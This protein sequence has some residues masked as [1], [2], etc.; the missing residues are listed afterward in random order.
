MSF[1]TAFISTLN[2]LP[3]LFAI[4]THSSNSDINCQVITDLCTL[5]PVFVAFVGLSSWVS[6]VALGVKQATVT[7]LPPLRGKGTSRMTTRKTKG[8]A[9]SQEVLVKQV[10]YYNR[11]ILAHV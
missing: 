3:I 2:L 7:A 4:N 8:L 6:G 1:V 10:K 5:I 9:L 11:A